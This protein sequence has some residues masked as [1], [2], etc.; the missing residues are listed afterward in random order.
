MPPQP[1]KQDSSRKWLWVL[2]L[3][4]GIPCLMGTLG[5]VG[6]MGY[7]V[8]VGNAGPETM[9]V[10]GSR[11]K[12]PHLEKIKALGLL[13]EGEKILWFYSDAMVDP[14]EGMYFCTDRKVVVYGSQYDNSQPT[15]PYDTITDAVLSPGQGFLVD[16]MITITLDDGSE[17]AFPV[18]TEAGGDAQFHE[19]IVERMAGE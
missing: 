17:V 5:F 1:P 6:C 3:C 12:R 13:E 11:V 7:A 9:A 14:T 16:S 4:I 19:A 8:Y 15:F 18:S 10:T 2:G